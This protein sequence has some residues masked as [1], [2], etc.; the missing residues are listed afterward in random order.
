MTGNPSHDTIRVR[1]SVV[2][3][4]EKKTSVGTS[5]FPGAEW[6]IPFINSKSLGK[7]PVSAK[8]PQVT[9]PMTNTITEQNTES[10]QLI[11][12]PGQNQS[13]PARMMTRGNLHIPIIFNRMVT[14][15]I[16][17][18]KFSPVNNRGRISLKITRI[19]RNPRKM[20]RFFLS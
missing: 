14:Y 15:L 2:D 5:R 3:E 9:A 11:L 20:N 16:G 6:E 1:I 4:K 18:S 8:N 13:I 10:F 7:I 19:N 17:S 12:F